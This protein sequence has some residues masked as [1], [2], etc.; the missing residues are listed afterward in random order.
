MQAEITLTE[1]GIHTGLDSHS[2]RRLMMK[3]VF[4]TPR[5]GPREWYVS[6]AGVEAYMQRTKQAV[7]PPTAGLPR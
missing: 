4:G 7:E 3:G 5:R 2:V 1:A 6:R